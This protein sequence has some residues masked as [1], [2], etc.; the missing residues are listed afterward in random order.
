MATRLELEGPPVSR[1]QAEEVCRLLGYEPTDVSS[2]VIAGGIG[3]GTVEV[4]V[5][6]RLRGAGSDHFTKFQ[7]TD[8]DGYVKARIR[9]EI[10]KN[11][12]GTR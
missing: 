6:P 8:G 1:G 7:D 11:A 5:W 12:E 4:T 9:H 2:V 3:S 10:R